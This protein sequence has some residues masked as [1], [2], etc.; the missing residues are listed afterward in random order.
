MLIKQ[1][2]NPNTR[3]LRILPRFESRLR[4]TRHGMQ[5]AA[6][7]CSIQGHFDRKMPASDHNFYKLLIKMVEVAGVEPACP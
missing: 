7:R 3:F 5:Y 6:K 1:L 4:I 2:T